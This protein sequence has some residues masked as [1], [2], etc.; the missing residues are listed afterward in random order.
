MRR[1]AA[2]AACLALLGAAVALV[3]AASWAP[4]GAEP[5][6]AAEC[7][8]Q[9]H[10]KKVVKW[11]KRHGKWRRVT[12]HR[13]WWTR[14]CQADPGGA[15]SEPAP[16]PPAPAPNPEPEPVANRLGVRAAEYYFTLSRASV[17]AGAV[18]VEL[19]NRG[20]DAH[21][22]HLQRQGGGSE[23]VLELEET[24]SLQHTSAS[25]DLPAGTYELWCSLPGHRAAGMETTLA[26]DD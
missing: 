15:A 21:D 14:S 1:A 5:A 12:R 26:V 10:T 23:P 25:F 17:A 19:D 22:L 13:H 16:A 4:S 7:T 18:T 2:T 6:A 20:E 9:R 24:Q 8:W 11:V 3:P